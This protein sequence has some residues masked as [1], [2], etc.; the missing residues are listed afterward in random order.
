MSN[1][2]S[3]D[4]IFYLRHSIL[5]Y[6][7]Q[8]IL[9]INMYIYLIYFYLSLSHSLCIFY[10]HYIASKNSFQLFLCTNLA[11]PAETSFNKDRKEEIMPLL[12][13]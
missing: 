12:D 9:H 4:T 10:T 6:L 8:W 7:V 1:C 2:I 5:C 11:K 3:N 13:L